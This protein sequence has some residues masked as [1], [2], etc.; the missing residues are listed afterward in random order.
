[1]DATTRHDAPSTRDAAGATLVRPSIVTLPERPPSGVVTL[2]DFFALRFPRIPEAVWRERFAAGKV[3]AAA[4][5]VAAD[6]PYRPLLELHYRRE[7]EREPPVRTDLAVV[8][9]DDDLLVVDKPPH[10]PVTPGGPW[11][12]HTLL[13]LLE[14]LTSC[15][16]LVPLHR[17]DRL[18]SGLVVLSRRQST[19]AHYVRMFQ[20]GAP[21]EKTYTAVCELPGGEPPERA[22]LEHHIRRSRDEHWRQVVVPG[23]APNASSQI[24]L[25]EARGRL[26]AYR[27]RPRTGRKHQIRVQ[28]AAA[29]LPILGDPL[30]GT[31]PFHDPEDLVTRLWLDAREIRVTGFPRPGGAAPLTAAWTSSRDPTA[32]LAGAAAAVSEAAAGAA[33]ASPESDRSR[34]RS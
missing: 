11:V 26:A 14:G 6:E 31:R 4:G 15:S 2:L 1:M 24:E 18:T 27:V 3:W 7:V 8:W 5:P 17:L 30:Y 16:E 21:V 33:S 10:L 28:L 20:P 9:S 34:R 12:R 13:H 19:R 23:E 32:M 25:I 29:G 22:V